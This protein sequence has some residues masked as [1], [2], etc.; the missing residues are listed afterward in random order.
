MSLYL[1]FYAHNF[2]GLFHTDALRK[3]LALYVV[4]ASCDQRIFFAHR[5][6]TTTAANT[7]TPN[8]AAYSAGFGTS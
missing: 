7:A 5:W 2:F 3:A 8:R 6:R 1:C 4:R